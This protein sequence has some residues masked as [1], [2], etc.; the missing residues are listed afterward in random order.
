MSAN[1]NIFQI[2]IIL[3]YVKPPI[4]RRFLVEDNIKLPD[5]HKVI[6]TIMGWSDTHLHQFIS[7]ERFYGV[8]S[9]DLYGETI[10]YKKIKLKDILKYENEK[11]KY[12][13]DFGDGWEHEI[14]LEK[15]FKNETIEKPI[16]LAGRRNCPPEDCGGP[17]GYM[18]MLKALSDQK[19]KDYEEYRSWIGD[20]FDSE[21][22][23]KELINILLGRKNYGSFSIL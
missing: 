17:Y 8:S 5:L 12:E 1:K 20:D 3:K 2:K 11:I 22:F 7:Q 18:N 4:W 10:D 23:D 13:Y 21:Y 19:N 16:C 15:V 6:Q 9:E 14:I